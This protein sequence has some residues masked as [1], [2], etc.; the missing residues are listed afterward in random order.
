M[1]LNLRHVQTI[2]LHDMRSLPA[3]IPFSTLKADNFGNRTPQTGYQ[4]AMK[5]G[6]TQAKHGNNNNNNNNKDDDDNDTDNDMIMILILIL[7]MIM[8]IIIITTTTTMMIIS[9]NLCSLFLNV[10]IFDRPD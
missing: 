2:V 9:Q 8:I 6:H 4:L 5:S 3:F 7:I 1:T 10:Q